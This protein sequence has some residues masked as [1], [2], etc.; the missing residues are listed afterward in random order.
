MATPYEAAKE[1]HLRVLDQIAKEETRRA[2]TVKSL[3]E[4]EATIG[5]TML[6]ETRGPNAE[7]KAA[8][9]LLQARVAVEIRDKSLASLSR[10]EREAR[11]Q[12]KEAEAAQKFEE[13]AAAKERLDAHM[14]KVNAI[15]AQLKECE[16]GGVYVV[17]PMPTLERITADGPQE[18]TWPKSYVMRTEYNRLLA[19]AEGL[20]VQ[21]AVE[22]QQEKS[23]GLKR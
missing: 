9:E 19:R 18:Y 8:Q 1:E 12:I 17:K 15:L 13:A 21:A 10:Q 4:L 7:A 5:D 11:L 6:V 2:A 16:E 22:R 14:E 20:K 3:E 23:G